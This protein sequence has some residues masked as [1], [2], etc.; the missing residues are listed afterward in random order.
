MSAERERIDGHETDESL[1]IADIDRSELTAD[2]AEQVKG[3][4]GASGKKYPGN[5][6]I[7]SW[8][9]GAEHQQTLGS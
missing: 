2:A 1:P 8:S 5:I 6:E 4:D 9:F 3:G 7:A